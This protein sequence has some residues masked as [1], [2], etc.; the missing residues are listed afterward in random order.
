M[1]FNLRRVLC[2]VDFSEPSSRALHAA[3]AFAE[4]SHAQLSVLHVHQKAMPLV[5]A[6]SF[7]AGELVDPSLDV[8][9]REQLA[10][11]LRNLVSGEAGVVR[12][13]AVVEE[14]NDVAS[15]IVARAIEEHADLIVLGTHGRSG[16]QHFLLGSVAETVLRRAGCP[17]LTVPAAASGDTTRLLR[18][19][20]CALDFSIGGSA[21]L[22]YSRHLAAEAAAQ[23][24]LLH[25]IELPPTGPEFRRPDLADYRVTRF[26]YARQSMK[27][28][29]A[30]VRGTC[31]VRE[32]V[33]VGKPEC[34]ILR[35]ATEQES[36]LIVMGIHGRSAVDLAIFGSVT[37]S[38]VR[39][40]LC[41]VLTIP[42][43]AT[44]PM[45]H[46]SP[47]RR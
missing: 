36:D 31:D 38:V 12:S 22:H 26:E 44:Q 39:H 3:A 16:M 2:A 25:V 42:A 9:D 41:P 5:A 46:C 29:L 37:H 1:S 23:L 13:E 40:A 8:T 21:A 6:G 47:P 18:R 11:A 27:A 24:T 14:A 28:S 15:A 32:L 17:V 45:G 34:E 10:A 35:V 30:E 7:V 33:L 19:I 20:V 43:E 4:R